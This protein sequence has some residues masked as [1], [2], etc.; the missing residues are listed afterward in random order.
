ML[1]RPTRYSPPKLA[2]LKSLMLKTR[3]SRL[4]ARTSL[5]LW[6][7][8][9]PGVPPTWLIRLSSE[10]GVKAPMEKLTDCCAETAGVKMMPSINAATAD[11]AQAF[12][13]AR[14]NRC[15]GALLHLVC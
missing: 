2:P 5:Q 7:I 1:P 9:Q 14:A 4:L 11:V 6:L 15:I 13:P 3:K 12:R 10:N 8:R